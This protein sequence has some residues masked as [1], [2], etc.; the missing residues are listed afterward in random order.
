M[1]DPIGDRMKILE[2]RSA[3]A[4][5][6]QEAPVYARVDGRGFSRLTKGMERPFDHRMTKAM[7]ATATTMLEQTH[8]LA[9]YVQS[10]EISLGWAPTGDAQHF[11]GGK[12]QKMASVLAGMA[13][14]AFTRALLQDE[15][16]LSAW[17][18]KMPHFDARVVGLSSSEELAEM[19]AWRGQD[20]RRNGINQVARSIFPHRELQGKS[21][22]EVRAMLEDAGQPLRAFQPAAMNGVLLRRVLVERALSDDELARIPRE[23]RPEPGALFR[24]HKALGFCDVHPG[25]IQNLH[26]VLVCGEAPRLHVAIQAA[27]Q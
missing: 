26:D 17:V 23:R 9:A 18:E 15:D 19:F 8:A 27:H 16:G 5:F 4:P 25:N 2:R 1:K 13:T 22:R 12:P 20:A 14:A 7:L 24:R 10:D 21:T 6:E 3:G 11:F